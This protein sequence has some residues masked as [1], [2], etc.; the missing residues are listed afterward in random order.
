MY[1]DKRKDADHVSKAVR[2]FREVNP[3]GAGGH[4]FNV[5][6]AGGYFAQPTISFYNAAKFGM[7]SIY[8]FDLPDSIFYFIFPT[9]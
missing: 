1:R 9:S 8:I 2:I 7:Y 5:S 4:I 3:P 6:S